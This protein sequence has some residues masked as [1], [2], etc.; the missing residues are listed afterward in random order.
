[1]SLSV[2]A[3]LKR[4]LRCWLVGNR[5]LLLQC[6]EVLLER[7]HCIAGI[8]TSAPEIA[9]WAE[10]HAIVITPTVLPEVLLP[11]L[12]AKP[13]NLL[14][15]IGNDEIL[16]PAVLGVPT[17]GCV[18]YH[19]GPLPR[20]AGVHATSWA[21]LSGESSYAI[22]WHCMTPGID[23]GD[24][25]AQ[26]AVTIEPHDTAFQLNL[27]C[28]QAGFESFISLLT[29]WEAGQTPVR[30]PQDLSQRTLYRRFRRPPLALVLDW[31]QPAVSLERLCRATDFGPR[32]NSFGVARL[33]LSRTHYL[34]LEAIAQ[35]AAVSVLP[36]TVLNSSCH[37]L[38]VATSQGTLGIR[39]LASTDGEPLAEIPPVPIGD[40][41]PL[42]SAQLAALLTKSFQ[43]S[44]RAES[45]RLEIYRQYAPVQVPEYNAP[46]I[47]RVPVTWCSLPVSLPDSTR[48]S[49]SAAGGANFLL[50]AFVAFWRRKGVSSAYRLDAYLS[51]AEGLERLFLPTVPLPG[52]ADGSISVGEACSTALCAVEAAQRYEPIL[53]DLFFRYPGTPTPAPAEI[54]VALTMK[55]TEYPA[56][57]SALHLAVSPDATPIYLWYSSDRIAPDAAA[58]LAAQ[59]PRFVAS[60]LE[61]PSTPLRAV[62]LLDDEERDRVLY[63]WNDT[64]AS[65]SLD[66]SVVDLFA[67]HARH[68]PDATAVVYEDQS[69]TYGQL[70]R[71]AAQLA[72]WLHANG[73]SSGTLV[74]VFL[75]RCAD[76][77]VALL[78]ILKAGG[79]YVPL[80]PVYPDAR[81]EKIL[82]DTGAA[83]LITESTLDQRLA[84]R[85]GWSFRQDTDGHQL[86][87]DPEPFLFS[88]PFCRPELPAYLIYTSG[89][90]GTPKGVPIPHRALVNLMLSYAERVGFQAGDSVMAISSIGFDWSICDL[91]LP[92][93][94][95]A[96]LEI[97][98]TDVIRDGQ[99]L[100]ERVENGTVTFLQ[101]TPGAWRLMLAGGWSQRHPIK[102]VSAGEAMSRELA[103]QI[104]QRVA[105]LFNG[106]GPT[107]TTVISCAEPITS[108]DPIHLGK[109]LANYRQ[110]VLDNDL[111]PVGVGEVGEICIAGPGVSPG[112]HRRPNL[113][114]EKFLLDPFRPESG[115]M[116]YRSGD[117]GRF[118]A[119]GRIE[120]V[121]RQDQQVKLRSFRIELGEIESQV[122]RTEQIRDCVVVLREDKPGQPRLV[123]F[124]VVAPEQIANFSGE[125]VL[126]GLRSQLPEYM[127]P[128]LLIPLRELPVTVNKK[129]DRRRLSTMPLQ[130]LSSPPPVVPEAAPEQSQSQRQIITIVA[131]I[132]GVEPEQI[133]SDHSFLEL[134]L[135]SIQLT[136][137]AWQIKNQLGRRIEVTACYKFPTPRQLAAHLTPASAP[138]SAPVVSQ[139]MPA[140][141]TLDTAIAIVGMAARIPGADE[142]DGFWR[143]VTSKETQIRPAPNSR[144]FPMSWPGGYLDQ[145]DHFDAA[146]FQISADE[147]ERLD[148]Q[149]RLLLE[150]CLHALEDAG[151]RPASLAGNRVGVFVGIAASEYQEILA[152]DGAAADGFSLNTLTSS[153]AANRV[154]WTFNFAGPS[155]AIDTGCS[156]SLLAVHRAMMALRQGECTLA[157]VA[158]VNLLLTSGR[159]TA[160]AAGGILSPDG[161]ARPF[162]AAGNG[163]VRGEGVG[164]IVLKPTQAALRDG[165]RLQALIRG[166]AV[167]HGGRTSSLAGPNPAAQAATV[168]AAL[169]Q[170]EVDTASVT[171]VELQGSGVPIGDHYEWSA[172]RDVFTKPGVTARY[173]G[174]IKAQIGHLECAAGVISLIKTVLALRHRT[175]PA[176][177]HCQEIHPE[178]EEDPSRFSLAR[179]TIPWSVPSD[180]PR[181]AG[182][183]GFG[184]GGTIA[185]V[186]LEEAPDTQI[187]VLPSRREIILLSAHNPESLRENAVRLMTFVQNTPTAALA[188]IAFTLR[189]GR[190]QLPHRLVF[191][192]DSLQGLL[193]EIEHYLKSPPIPQRGID[194]ATLFDDPEAVALLESWVARCRWEQLAAIWLQGVSIPWHQ[195]PSNGARRIALPGYAFQ[196]RRYWSQ[197]PTLNPTLGDPLRER[198]LKLLGDRAQMLTDDSNLFSLG[199]DSLGAL[200]LL[201]QVMPE[202]T[203][204]LRL[205]DLLV[206]PTLRGLRRL[207]AGQPT[208]VVEFPLSAMQLFFWEFEQLHPGSTA[209]HSPF[210]F[211]LDSQVDL[212]RLREALEE[213]VHRYSILRSRLAVREGEPLQGIVPIAHFE[214]PV[215]PL[216]HADWQS[217]IR[218]EARRPFSDLP[219]SAAVFDGGS[220]QR[221]LLVTLHH[222]VL[223][224]ISSRLL[225]ERL[226]KAYVAL[227]QQQ[228]LQLPDDTSYSDFVS[229][230]R[231]WLQSAEAEQYRAWW[232]RQFPQGIPPL[233]LPTEA[234]PLAG[235]A[236]QGASLGCEIPAVEWNTLVRRCQELT[237]TPTI[238]CLSAWVLL[239][240]RRCD[241]TEVAITLPVAGRLQPQFAESIG[242][243]LN[244]I[245]LCVEISDQTRMADLWHQ[246]QQLIAEALDRATLPLP[247]IL[248]AIPGKASLHAAFYGQTWAEP[249]THTV[250]RQPIYEIMQE[251]E[252]DLALEMLPIIEGCRFHLKYN[253]ALFCAAFAAQLLEQFTTLLTESLSAPA[254]VA[255]EVSFLPP[256]D[257]QRV[258]DSWNDT[259]A[260]F[261]LD[262]PMH[263]LFRTQAQRSPAATAV[264]DS[265]RTLTYQELNQLS[266]GLAAGLQTQG[267]SGCV[268]G[269]LLKRS[270][271][272]PVALLGILKSG[273][274]YLPLDPNLPAERLRFLLA[275]S[276]ATVILTQPELAA[277]LPLQGSRCL[278]LNDLLSTQSPARVIGEI[279]YLIYTSGS[280]GEPKGTLIPHRALTNFLCAMQERLGLVPSDRLLAITTISFDIAALELFLPLLCGATVDIAPDGLARDGLGLRAALES[281]SI[282][283]LQ[284]TPPTYW[285]LLE[286][287]WRPPSNLRL[288]C[289]GEPL[290]ADLAA[291]LQSGGAELW[292]LYGPTEATVWTTAKRIEPGQPVTIGRPLA[293]TRA[294]ILDAHLQPVAVGVVGELYLGGE[295][296]AVGYHQRPGLTQAQFIVNPFGNGRLY[297]TGDLAQWTSQGEILL[298]GRVDQQIKLRGVRIEI[299]EIE[300]SLRRLDGVR[301]AAVVLRTDAGGSDQLVAFLQ[302]TIAA[303]P[304]ADRAGLRRWLPEVMIP[305]RYIDLAELPLTPNCKIDR[306]ALTTLA[307]D[308]FIPPALPSTEPRAVLRD[309]LTRTVAEVVH[310]APEQIQ[311]HRHLG[312]YGLDSV[313]FTKLA[314]LLSRD[315]QRSV[316]P[317]IFYQYTTVAQLEDHLALTAPAQSSPPP[318][319]SFSTDEEPIAIVAMSGI[320]PQSV[321]LD[322]FWQHLVEGNDLITEVPADRWAAAELFDPAGGPGR[323]A[324]RWGGFV[325]T[326]AEF[327]AALF[328]IS[329]REAEQMDPQQRLLLQCTWRLFEDAGHKPADFA[330]RRCG[331][332]VG[333]SGFDYNEFLWSRSPGIE[334]HTLSGASHA[335]LANRISYVF[336]LRGPSATIDT[337]CS[338]S[339]V[340]IHRAVTA[341][342]TDECEAAIAGGVSVILSPTSYIALSQTGMLSPEGRCKTFD[343]SADGYVRGEGVALLLLRPLGA[344]IAD[345]DPILGVIRGSAENHGG[346]TNSLTAPSASA[347]ADLVAAAYRQSGINHRTVSYIEAHGTGTALGDPIEIN[348]LKESFAKLDREQGLPAPTSPTCGLGSLKTNF[349]HLEA[350]A[351]AAGVMKVLLAMRYKRLPGLLHH[352][353]TNPMIHL[354]GSP[355]R[356]VKQSEPWLAQ[357]GPDGSPLPLRAGVS[358]FG[359]G[360]SNAHVVLEEFVA[361]T[362]KSKETGPWIFPLSA[363]DASRLVSQCHTLSAWLQ[364]NPDADIRDVAYTLQQG[365]PTFEHR[366]AFITSTPATLSQGLS[367]LGIDTLPTGIVYLDVPLDTRLEANAEGWLRGE[368]VSWPHLDQA[369]RLALPGHPFERTRFWLSGAAVMTNAEPATLIIPKLRLRTTKPPADQV[370]VTAI[371]TPPPAASPTTSLLELLRK[372]L[373]AVLYTSESQLDPQRSFVELGV[374]SILAIE[375][376]RKI[377]TILNCSVKV[378]DLYDHL[379]LEGLARYLDT[380]AS[381]PPT[382]SSPPVAS[383]PSSLLDRLREILAHVLYV[384]PDRI[385]SQKSFADLGVDSILGVEFVRELNREFGVA[386]SAATLYDY[387]QL[388]QL[389]AH[390]TDSLGSVPAIPQA[391]T[392]QPTTLEHPSPTYPGVWSSVVGGKQDSSLSPLSSPS[393]TIFDHTPYPPS[394]EGAIAIV[395]C[396][397]RFPGAPNLSRFWDNLEAGLASITKFPPERRRGI[398]LKHKIWHGGFLEDVDCFDPLFFN[399]SPT[400]AELMDPQQRLFLEQ[401]Y[402]AIEDAG[403]APEQLAGCKGGIFAGVTGSDRYAEMLPAER[404]AQEMMGNAAAILAGRL[405]FFLDLRGPALTIDTACSSSLV[406][407]HLACRSLLSGETDIALAGG[408]TLYLSEKAWVEMEQAGM[409]APDGRCKTFDQQADGFV[410]GEGV[411]IV[412]LKRLDQALAD[413]DSIYGVIRSTGVNHDGRTNGLTAPSAKSQAALELQVYR[414]AGIDPA[415]ITYVEAHGTGTKL[416]D[417]IEVEA[418]TRA[419]RES[420]AQRQFC[421]IGSVKTNIGHTTAAAGVAGV[422]KVIGGMQRRRIPPTLNCETENEHIAF[423]ESPFFVNRTLQ[424][425]EPPSGIPRRAAVSSFGFSGTNAHLLLEEPPPAASV[426]RDGQGAALFLVS[427]KTLPALTR[428]IQELAAVLSSGTLQGSSTDIAFTLARGR[429][430]F[431]MRAAFV[432]SSLDE[433][434][435]Q[436]SAWTPPGAISTPAYPL[437][438]ELAELTVRELTHDTDPQS[439]HTRLQTL[440]DIYCCGFA[441]PLESLF[442]NDSGRRISLPG[443][444]FERERY[445]A[446]NQTAAPEP[447]R[448]HSVWQKYFSPEEPIVNQHR[449]QA[450]PTLPGA[451]LLLA[452]Y[453]AALQANPGQQYKIADLL[454]AQPVRVSAG[455]VTL[456]IELMPSNSGWQFQARTGTGS[457]ALLHAEGRLVPL[458]AAEPVT[459]WRVVDDEPTV[460][461]QVAEFYSAMCELGVTYGSVYQ[462]LESL[463]ATADRAVAHLSPRH[464]SEPLPDAMTLDAALQIVGL[465]AR[466]REQ[467]WQQSLPVAVADCAFLAPWPNK[468]EVRARRTG[469]D[470]FDIQVI[471]SDNQV[472][473][474]VTG[475]TLRRVSTAQNFTAPALHNL[476]LQ[477]KLPAIAPQTWTRAD[478]HRNALN[479]YA[480]LLSRQTLPRLQQRQH[481][482]RPT[483][484]ALVTAL[485]TL[486]ARPVTEA[487]D[488]LRARYPELQQSFSLLERC[489]TALPSVAC[490]EQLATDV[491]FPADAPRLL[492]VIYTN[493]PIATAT[494]AAVGEL[495]AAAHP[496]AVLEFGAG[497]GAT[498]RAVAAVLHVPVRYLFTDV[499]TAFLNS[500]RIQFPQWEFAHFDVRRS[501]VSQNIP[502]ASFDVVFGTNVLHVVSDLPLALQHL[503]SLLRPGGIL[504]LNEATTVEDYAVLTFG[505]TPGWWQSAG[506]P[507]RLPHSPLLSASAWLQ[508]LRDAD[509]QTV[510]EWTAER[511]FYGTCGQSIFIASAPPAP[512]PAVEQSDSVRTYVRQV[513][514]D[515]LKLP[516][517]RL[518]D[519]ISFE[520]YGVDS[521]VVLEI[522]RAFE[523]DLGRLPATLL[524]ENTTV[525]A[526]AAYFQSKHANAL[527]R[528]LS[529]VPTP[530]PTPDAIAPPPLRSRSTTGRIAIIAVSG[531]YPLSPDLDTLWNNLASGCDGV[532]PV[533]DNRWQWQN[534]TGLRL[535]TAQ[536]RQ[537]GYLDG[538][539]RFDPLHFGISPREAVAMDPQQ[540]LFLEVAASALETAGYTQN[541]LSTIDR[542]VGVF[543][544]VMT[545]DYEWLAA[546]ATAAGLMTDAHSAHWSIANR[547]S[548]CLNLSGPSLAIDTACSASLSAI[549]LACE[550]LRRG[551]CQVAIAGGVNLILHP[552]HLQRLDQAGMLSP[553]D[554]CHSFGSDA[555]GFADGEGVGAVLLKPL[556]SAIADGDTIWGAILGSALNA[557]GR[558]GGF[559]IPNPAAQ[560]TVVREA[561]LR[562]GIEPHSISYVEAHGTGT[563]LGDPIEIAGLQQVFRDVAPASCALGSVKSNFGHL[564]AAAGVLGLTKVLLQMKHAQLAPTLHATSPNPL[565]EWDSLPFYL[566]QVLTPWQPSHGLRR[567]GVSSFGAG[568]A[569]AHLIV[570]EFPAPTQANAP[571]PQPQL[572]VLSARDPERLAEYQRQLYAHLERHPETSLAHLAWTLQAG[573]ESYSERWFILAS[574]IEELLAA[575]SNNSGQRG[576]VRSTSPVALDALNTAI[577][578]RDL[579]KI[580]DFWLVGAEINWAAL[581][582]SSDRR[583][584]PLPTYP[585]ARERYW[586]PTGHPLST[587]VPSAPSPP[588]WL[589]VPQ[590]EAYPIA[591]WQPAPTS[592]IVLLVISAAIQDSL[593]IEQWHRLHRNNTLLVAEVTSEEPNQWLQQIAGRVA[594]I[595]RIYFLT[596]V[597]VEHRDLLDPIAIEQAQECGVLALFRLIKLLRREGPSPVD[598]AV[599]TQGIHQS[600]D[601][602]PSPFFAALSG[603]VRSLRREFPDWRVCCFDVDKNVLADVRTLIGWIGAEWKSGEW[604]EVSR[605]GDQ[606]RVRVLHPAPPEAP[607]ALHWRPGGTYLI[608]GGAG[609][610]GI[611]TSLHLAR[612]AQAR[613]ILL[614]RRPLSAQQQTRLAE[615]E[616]AGGQVLYLQA[617][618]TDETSLTAAVQA[619]RKHFGPIQGAFHSALVLDDRTIDRMDEATFRRVLAS[620]VT[621]SVLLARTLATEPLDFLLFFSSAESFAG[622]AGQSNYSAGCTFQDAYARAL[623][624]VR[625]L[626]TKTIN[627]G[628]W[629]SVGA[630]ASAEY[631]SRLTRQGLISI[632]PDEGMRAI[633]WLLDKDTTQVLAIKC[634]AE[635]LERL[636]VSTATAASALQDFLN[637]LDRLKAAGRQHLLARLCA[638]GAPFE[639]QRPVNRDA[640]LAALGVCPS[641]EKL[642]DAVLDLLT[643][644]GLLHRELSSWTLTSLSPATLPSLSVGE[645]PAHEQLLIR[646]LQALPAVLRGDAL[647]TDVLFAEEGMSLVSAMYQGDPVNDH[648][649]RLVAAYVQQIATTV[650]SVS[651]P[652][653]ILEIGAG[654]GGTTA[655][656]LPKLAEC[657]VPF[658]YT[659]TDISPAFLR[660]GRELFSTHYPQVQFGL[661]DIERDPVA[662]GYTSQQWDLVLATNVLHAT[663]NLAPTLQRVRTLIR[664]QGCL[665][666]NEAIV[667]DDFLT[668]TFGLLPGWWAAEDTQH[669]HPHSPLAPRHS[670]QA[671]LDEA[672]FTVA[673]PEPGFAER[674]FFA[675]CRT[676]SASLGN[677]VEVIRE[678]LAQTLDVPLTRILE[679]IPFL[680]LGLDSLTA[681]EVVKRIN[682]RLGSTLLKSMDLYNYPTVEHLSR[683]LGEL[684]FTPLL[685]TAPQSD[686]LRRLLDQ[687]ADGNLDV[688]DAV[689]AFLGEA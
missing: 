585:F 407:I 9:S 390:L 202:A 12:T 600:P 554:C 45:V 628:Y 28:H 551:E 402:Q 430:H 276:G 275:D 383:A 60:A 452:A 298:L 193:T 540:R 415:T 88:H 458:S 557:G 270:V 416:G 538:V 635:L 389:A 344:A 77:M 145:I 163:L 190:D 526:L 671:L 380:T 590:W 330:G 331:V 612:H 360:G 106:Y 654:T 147:A 234:A 542:Q 657:G 79:T 177:L 455:G 398:D 535:S 681:I 155:E 300:A 56:L 601:V 550:S 597:S 400:D 688:D 642:L 567:A 436:L 645:L 385:S 142:L 141:P 627:W 556:E 438:A 113:N 342:R 632:N 370:A 2:S 587:E 649:N 54:S 132:L 309:I 313:R 316:E 607:P 42:V 140:S 268:V 530:L 560:A 502:T 496:T 324:S 392:P 674:V 403:Y 188:D 623:C 85:P 687:V 594:D 357:L 679:D 637:R 23:D 443:Y 71:R 519:T 151:E 13:I 498:S 568:G 391:A 466:D 211:W 349:G 348:A 196:G 52:E 122:L 170:A 116:L 504:I 517:D 375:F 320:F 227:T 592:G 332:Y 195:A 333:A 337:A 321:N 610:I 46:S 491:L 184:F 80:D 304:D 201:Y 247:E 40:V 589:Y 50:A 405:A 153:I 212:G 87:A 636:G 315:L 630:V 6:A 174:S 475:L 7:G 591:S 124:V 660:Q 19:D 115:D 16:Q 515:V 191:I 310:I 280:T 665:V 439:R 445:W 646:C 179:Q 1:M 238:A 10:R 162:D 271:F 258:L 317:P 629:G 577:C 178:L 185:H 232:C 328:G 172:L 578:Q 576:R 120:F 440:R 532:R 22:T 641:S 549:H 365:R 249:E 254:G 618:A 44:L 486:A 368:T 36:G 278:L 682:Q 669:R 38:L 27:K 327:D 369:K 633:E 346:R 509:F 435:A 308:N 261:P 157:L 78:G 84:E 242:T 297:R 421:A 634:K 264:S 523:K 8:T 476:I 21:L 546:E 32:P 61:T 666:L 244:L 229:F 423:A 287:G 611:E 505:L 468:A 548:Y 686:E 397:G 165:N 26:P 5:G 99:R 470:R 624:Q 480:C 605:Q 279:A 295:G 130:E 350:A 571:A 614:G 414:C 404:P 210:A 218:A 199:L 203:P 286:A 20:Y 355:F 111:N 371:F 570:E 235:A 123:G 580:A 386:L 408:I 220:N 598:L 240:A 265:S 17:L 510:E 292:N 559:T 606:R 372:E 169:Q 620:K 148:P 684:P 299:G 256:N 187:P 311:P 112:Y 454:W 461:L 565:I 361:P 340:A 501:P 356:L 33:W 401:A 335:I 525:N 667:V 158:G 547:V 381:V 291:S 448:T 119:N 427:A 159:F 617:D 248:A 323:S 672:G 209:W 34:V 104:Q 534:A 306:Q 378:A 216:N 668:M 384:Q 373:A 513:L 638:A 43:E 494:N 675:Q 101:G 582:P 387:P 602:L 507:D 537:A 109:P 208:A 506:K 31:T 219:I 97:L 255:A 478:A 619:G 465:L 449:V 267:L 616:R 613:L 604:R 39:R 564:E 345:R 431:P 70:N 451:A 511:A 214:L 552:R 260:A 273:A 562:S 146:F 11:V 484:Q 293:N 3:P 82:E 399:I 189:V 18:N 303:N 135:D 520:N 252:I 584:I 495:V 544:G 290:P 625:G 490:G 479:R 524:F 117:L 459:A 477:A 499:S 467:R 266:D 514:S 76:L 222:R 226:E 460:P 69:Y 376:V 127:V 420:T 334:A 603:F 374:D 283:V 221:A 284:A 367:A 336:D 224:G 64:A 411:G 102:L 86:T 518:E 134:G 239:L 277:T 302:R 62:P 205:S 215:Y 192:V 236:N 67:T 354:E 186:L 503:R 673:P 262:T 652:F 129:V 352:Q 545:A 305:S 659:Y 51:L 393:A 296:L 176:T 263:E 497:T 543:V 599:V 47:S 156:S 4:T 217:Q 48:T 572:F 30:Q 529:T 329:P 531:R 103:T 429:S 194:A 198:V 107:E 41:L 482:I 553:Q 322:E 152:R 338:S 91:F 362:V 422:L 432:A 312:E 351:G 442:P 678:A 500:A 396:S 670:W 326:L 662:Q 144:Q 154:S 301:D 366:V 92:L 353:V 282:T 485:G 433:L 450:E 573:R 661:L 230:E 412:V 474:N 339:L 521:L 35:E 213:I 655:S 66:C 574:T 528:V 472:A 250:L 55:P 57:S 318:S 206:D 105:T 446:A 319:T 456:Q 118:L 347:Q 508:H 14:W 447:V 233:S 395:G 37:E 388:D 25:L 136:R 182:V 463:A 160:L 251:G 180:T 644:A 453:E 207:V 149:Q 426:T 73:V 358:S 183:H 138:E 175:I 424:P 689:A 533:P 197:P 522:N 406:A 437:L 563:S 683:R 473:L 63:Q 656:V 274:I 658:E 89:S 223:D 143:I 653:R 164:V 81:L 483:Y 289:G 341:L 281:S 615:V 419:F 257:R 464:S 444:P 133:R 462:Q 561:L 325:D 626:P 410:P 581:H 651:R 68:R 131:G 110:Y 608:L 269:V 166:S 96:R 137:L 609:G 676:P 259:A 200:R 364:S 647:G 409:L 516:P 228:P 288:L 677:S 583:W 314:I 59:F 114:A 75:D 471:G 379:N 595:H 663:R 579:E 125:T 121:S 457:E 539:D 231:E 204:P 536:L 285:M 108:E 648:C 417:P 307:I 168:R 167:S 15:S 425:W 150:T 555:D 489:A 680:D 413:G 126:E 586:I 359:F 596:G 558:T 237:L 94:H 382:V 488:S 434:R 65:Y 566:P 53:R 377:S 83:F 253:P 128:S 640:L 685:S 343:A 139:A 93:A 588:G 272:L 481:E 245:P 72:A 639:S 527:H 100:V 161:V 643:R 49:L 621:T 575:L 441:L 428:R 74:G 418:L 650:A 493:S 512:T 181:R 541:R 363:F 241:Q 29:T 171:Y 664:P 394:P 631:Q 225:F 243:Y 569:N 58:R 98:P 294:Y 246:V 24:I 95:G 487:L 469:V 173:I 622:D 593:E 90:T 492:D